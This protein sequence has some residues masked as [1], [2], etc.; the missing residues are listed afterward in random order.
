MNVHAIPRHLVPKLWPKVSAWLDKA[1]THSAGE[2]N[3]DQLQ[4]LV[5]RGDQV[6][7]IA[8]DDAGDLLGAAT[9]AFVLY[10]AAR[11][12]FITA[13]G[14]RMLANRDLFAQLCEWARLE[15]C[16]SVQGTAFESSARLWKEKLGFE[17]IYR[18]V[19]VK[20]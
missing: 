3:L 2:Y 11:V 20:L 6:L 18:I 1:M 16:T 7:M 19:E 5:V 15:G 10:P 12:A 14:G 4:A 9:V 8:V 17:E 13:I